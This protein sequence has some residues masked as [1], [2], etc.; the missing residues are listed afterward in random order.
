MLTFDYRS[1]III[2]EYFEIRREKMKHKIIAVFSALVLLCSVAFAACSND[3]EEVEVYITQAQLS[4]TAEG[5]CTA[6]ISLEDDS[7]DT[8]AEQTVLSEASYDLTG[9]SP[10][11]PDAEL[12]LSGVQLTRVD[13]RT[14]QV[15]FETPFKGQFDVIYRLYTESAVTTSDRGICIYMTGEEPDIALTGECS[16]AYY[17]ADT[18]TLD[19]TFIE[20][21]KFVSDLSSDMFK[22]PQGFG[23]SLSVKRVSD[24]EAS[25][26]IT[27]MPDI[28]SPYFDVVVS[29]EAI[30]NPFAKD[31]TLNVSYYHPYVGDGERELTEDALKVTGAQLPD[32]LT[33]KSGGLSIANY[34]ERYVTITEQNYDAESNSYSYILTRTAAATNKNLTMQALTE[35]LSLNASLTSEYETFTYSFSVAGAEPYVY[36][37]TEQDYDNDTVTVSVSVIGGSFD[38]GITKD[39]LT[40]SGASA[41]GNVE[42]QNVTASGFDI[43][44][45]NYTA[46]ATG[47]LVGVS[48]PKGF[49]AGASEDIKLS[50]FVP[51]YDDVRGIDWAAL[52]TKLGKSAATSAV[53]ALASAGVDFALPYIYD[54]FGIDTTDPDIADIKNQLQ[55]LTLAVDNI[56]HDVQNVTSAIK[57]SSQL[58]V[59]NDFQSA[60]TI[61]LSTYRTLLSNDDV[62]AY[63]KAYN[64]DSG[65]SWTDLANNAI[66]LSACNEIQSILEAKGFT[67]S[68]VYDDWTSMYNDLANNYRSNNYNLSLENLYDM[69][70]FME[71]DFEPMDIE[72][73]QQVLGVLRESASAGG[74]NSELSANKPSGDT[75]TKFKSAVSNLQIANGYVASVINFGSQIMST[76]AGLSKG[77]IGLYFDS[78]NNIYNFESQTI[79]AKTAF[80]SVVQN[81]YMTNAAIAL[82]Y[83]VEAVDMNKAALRTQ[84][85][86]VFEVLDAAYTQIDEMTARA[87]KGNDVILITGGTVSKTMNAYKPKNVDHFR[88]WDFAEGGVILSLDNMYDMSQRAAKRGLPLAQD[89]VSAGF[90]NVTANDSKTSQYVYF[91]GNVTREDKESMGM[92]VLKTLG[93]VFSNVEY[94]VSDLH[95]YGN[96]LTQSGTSAASRLNNQEFYRDRHYTRVYGKSRYVYDYTYTT[97]LFFMAAK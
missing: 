72:T 27:N 70:Q 85:A 9:T 73:C 2:L 29:A 52:G 19:L 38:N 86:Q 34:A 18:L 62:I 89:L 93:S 96:F 36:T 78:I 4:Q 64:G 60:Q 8:F 42:V 90:S 75:V 21:G 58:Q 65:A 24:S 15:F 53:G 66:A 81:V 30:D 13:D 57:Q 71:E 74:Y 69:L 17:G 16:G 28:S 76:S 39:D 87:A 35:I 26:T 41:F 6:Y 25:L 14:A 47:Y 5:V 31:I 77:I 55:S 79:S 51:T 63:V 33:G 67:R 68:S 20:E 45:S 94:L 88:P 80:V 46:G 11:Y 91:C 1:T 22:L 97:I 95:Y 32:G 92:G 23:G 3:A 49:V 50:L 83:C 40:I 10:E 12:T 54:F 43:V 44:F 37:S 59:L 7:S 48:I 56:A 61:L 82:Q 84:I